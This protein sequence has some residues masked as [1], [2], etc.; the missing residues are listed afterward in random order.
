VLTLDA[1]KS[2][3]TR[4]MP[5]NKRSIATVNAKTSIGRLLNTL[6]VESSILNPTKVKPHASADNQ[7]IDKPNMES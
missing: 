5:D 7:D 2:F 4:F 1:V 6:T 3:Q